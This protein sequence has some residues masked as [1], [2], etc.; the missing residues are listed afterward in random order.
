[1]FGNTRKSA[2]KLLLKTD[3]GEVWIAHGIIKLNE[4]N[5]D[6]LTW[7]FFFWEQNYT[8]SVPAFVF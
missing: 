7:I 1:M 4:M 2:K 6:I 5:T 8:C 3:F